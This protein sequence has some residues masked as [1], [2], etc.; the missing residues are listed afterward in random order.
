MF[1][2]MMLAAAAA[3]GSPESAVAQVARDYVE[4][5]LDGDAVRVAR[6]LHPDLAKRAVKPT[7]PTPREALPLRRMTA[8]ELIQLTHDGALKRPRDKW[9]RDVRVLD[10]TGDAAVARVETP[11]FVDY[12]NLGRFGD[13]WMIVNALWW[14]KP[15]THAPTSTPTPKP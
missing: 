5:Q 12:L 4:G 3:T 8:D 9:E 2:S 11:W 10:V 14:A 15:R 13:R 1:M 6:V 7:G